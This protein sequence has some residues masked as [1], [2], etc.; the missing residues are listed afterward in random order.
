MRRKN[1]GA[2]LKNMGLFR[3]YTGASILSQ[4]PAAPIKTIGLFMG[5]VE[6]LILSQGYTTPKKQFVFVA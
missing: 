4:G 5:C 2:Y 6:A 3:G 1:P